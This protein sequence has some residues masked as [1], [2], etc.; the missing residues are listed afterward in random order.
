MKKYILY[1]ILLSVLLVSCNSTN[2]LAINVQKPALVTL[3]L[4]V[5]NIIVVNNS[6]VQPSDVGHKDIYYTKESDVSVSSDSLNIILTQAFAQFLN[7][8]GFFGN[9]ITYNIPLRD[10]KESFLS[11]I[12]VSNE[13]IKQITDSTESNVLISLDRLIIQ[14]KLRTSNIGNSLNSEKLTIDIN[15][16]LRVYSP[17]GK[18]AYPLINYKDSVAWETISQNGIYFMEE[19]PSRREALKFAVLYAADKLVK[20]FAPY[21]EEQERWYYTD[22]TTEMKEASVKA[23]ANKWTEAALIWGNIYEKEK[24]SLKKARLASNIAL[25]NEM[26]DD[27]ENAVTWI[28]ISFDTFSSVQQKGA[29]EDAELTQLYKAELEQRVKDFK[30]LD[31]QEG[32]FENSDLE[33]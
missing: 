28:N 31:L 26:L 13:R 2:W 33:F 14:S 9:V 23:N 27:L 12:A 11:E 1:S 20:M 29:N 24:N 25:A 17:D 32:A 16:N 21:W 18:M 19:I 22:G 5:E 10:K 7:E 3:P 15:A 30:K 4:T 6:A 8:E